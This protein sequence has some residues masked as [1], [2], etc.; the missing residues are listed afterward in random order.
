MVRLIFDFFFL[1]LTHHPSFEL[2]QLMELQRSL[3]YTK[4]FATISSRIRLVV[5]SYPVESITNNARLHHTLNFT[6]IM[7]LAMHEGRGCVSIGQSILSTPQG[8]YFTLLRNLGLG[9]LLEGHLMLGHT[10]AAEAV[11]K[12]FEELGFDR[13]TPLHRFS[14]LTYLCR[15]LQSQRLFN[16]DFCNA[17]EGAWLLV[18][19][20]PVRAPQMF[21][22]G[23]LIQ[24]TIAAVEAG[25]LLAIEL[26]ITTAETRVE[27]LLYRMWPL[28]PM[29]QPWCL[30]LWSYQG[31]YFQVFAKQ[32]AKART[33]FLKAEAIA[34][35]L[36]S[37]AI[38]GRLLLQRARYAPMAERKEL[39]E[40]AS[41]RLNDG[42]D[43]LSAATAR[44]GL[45]RLTRSLS[46]A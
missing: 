42:S 38:L 1:Q 41:R 46:H 5:Q 27:E 22:L 12:E 35:E 10:E 6:R 3:Y 19:S 9:M 17:L 43:P 26:S 37:D 16:E 4:H 21:C 40:E 33:C 13:I 44:D 29:F 36:H 25:P 31:L 45:S 2:A 28:G 30:F 7:F 8:Q 39:Y 20:I 18:P 11:L 23:L 32:P 24:A 34:R 15:I 14:H